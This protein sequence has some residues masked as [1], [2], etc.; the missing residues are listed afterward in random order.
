MYDE[1]I[2]NFVTATLFVLLTLIVISV[3]TAATYKLI[4]WIIGG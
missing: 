2:I 4:M 3:S 1:K